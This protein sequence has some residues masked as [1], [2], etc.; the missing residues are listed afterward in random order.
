MPRISRTVPLV[1]LAL[2]AL[3]GLSIV[4]QLELPEPTG[5]YA[6]GR[7]SR[8]WSDVS[9]LESVTDSPDDHREVPVEI[10]YPAEE[11]TGTATPYFKD[12]GHVATTLAASGEVSPLAIVGLRFVRSHERVEALLPNEAI[13]YPLI[14]LSPGNGTNV[15]FYAGIADELASHELY[16]RSVAG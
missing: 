12:L 5:P 16:V 11:A 3:L 4:V 7:T 2:V 1:G 9:R 13:S 15:E 6:V 14:L 8:R 10:W